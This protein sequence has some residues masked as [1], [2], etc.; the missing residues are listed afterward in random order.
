MNQVS[1]RVPL[2]DGIAKV[3][4]AMR[5]AADLPVEGSLHGALVFSSRAHARV[6]AVDAAAALAVEGVHAVFWHENTPAHRYNSSIWFA[7]QEVLA[8]EQM[9]PA[10]V[11]HVGDRVAAVVAD[12]EDI[13]RHA[14]RLI[15]VTYEDLP[16]V[17][18]P[19]AALAHSGAP[20]EADGTPTF[21]NPVAEERFTL[22]DPEAGFAAADLIVEAQVATPRS[23]HCAIETHCCLAM[24][25]PD[26][27][28]LILSPCQ[29]VFAVQAVVAQAL[30]LSSERL[31]VV[32]TPIGGSFG[33][34]AEPI[35]DPLCAFFALTLG[36]PVRIRYDRSET[37]TATRTRSSVT[38]RMRIGLSGAGRIVARDTE[39]LV[40][41]GAYCT[42]GNYL[43]GSMLQRLV[44]LYDVPAERYRGRA[45]YTNT[46]PAGAFRGYGSPQIHSIAE[47]VLDIA[48]RRLRMDPVDLRLRNL[49]R[50][51]SREPWQALDLGNARG[52]ECLMRGADEFEW[53]AR[54]Q[55]GVERGRWRRGIGTAAATHING[56]YPGFHEETTA[57][58]RLL[59]DGRV[60]LVCAMH[61]LGCGSDTTLAQIAGEML[62]LRASDIVIVQADT[63]TCAYDLGTRASRMTYICGEAIR[64]AAAALAAVI[65]AEAVRELN[66]SENDLL[67]EG[68]S[69]CRADGSGLS[70][71]ELAVRLGVRGASLPTATEIYR[72]TANPGSYAA[73]FAEVE[74]DTLTGRVRVTDYLAAHDVGRA[75][76][77]MLVEGQIHG[78]IQIGIGYA[79]YED[80]GIDRVTGVMR[81]DSFSRY[82]L[83]N[84]PEMPPM[85]VVLVEEGEPT[86]PFGAKAVGEIATIP[87]AA[88]VVNAV[89]HALD[90]ELT[91]L[92]L[93]PERIL[94]T[95]S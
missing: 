44:R 4:G 12:T 49:V 9:F 70:L 59:P 93:V 94:A 47:I 87:V 7:G 69:V 39:T 86:G 73:H 62:G 65:K 71:A 63:D 23:H 89:N 41:I 35:L 90:A 8:D 58:L 68:G 17:L 22:G 1:R 75:I 28:L 6:L 34:K 14:A 3:T 43:P 77:P 53:W 76:N 38:G 11:R 78:G 21:L 31:R 27:R 56:C 13:A 16:A 54:R 83:A 91:D 74:V 67:L 88:A 30:G 79:L 57:T 51:G 95:L 84:A 19:D 18:T 80:V 50:P 55:V 33:G 32:K 42:G 5:F 72:A 20:S 64:R 82:T 48:A 29:S 40:D 46:A 92:P 45:V 85:R 24:P 10:V 36:R 26:G 60:Q 61:D 52:R 37:F 81:G 25:E 2:I 66:A 15:A